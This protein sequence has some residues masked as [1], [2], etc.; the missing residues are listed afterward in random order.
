MFRQ[1]FAWLVYIKL[2]L[3]D[4]ESNY[5]HMFLAE[6]PSNNLNLSIYFCRS[7]LLW[8]SA[9]YC[10]YNTYELALQHGYHW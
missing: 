8:Q 1:L 2:S 10:D 6:S 5:I 9:N 4:T 3:P 7:A